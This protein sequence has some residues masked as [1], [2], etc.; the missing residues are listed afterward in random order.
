M[1]LRNINRIICQILICINKCNRSDNECNEDTINEILSELVIEEE[2]KVN[3]RK[4][5]FNFVNGMNLV[6]DKNPFCFPEIS[7]LIGK[8]SADINTYDINTMIFALL[9]TNKLVYIRNK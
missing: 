1:R 2:R 4:V 9:M 8:L 5:Q 6:V 7:D 3:D